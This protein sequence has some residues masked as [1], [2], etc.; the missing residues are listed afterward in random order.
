LLKD[1]GTR[2]VSF[3]VQSFNDEILRLNGRANKS[4]IFFEK[5]EVARKLGFDIVSVDLMSGLYGET[6]DNWNST[7][8]RLLELHPDNIA[9]Y[10]LE[11]YY[12]T[13]LFKMVRQESEKL[14]PLMTNDQEIALI[15]TAFDRL[16][17]EGKYMPANCFTLMSSPAKEH[18]HRKGIWQ[19]E[20][21]LGLGLS[22]H[23]YFNNH[24]YQNTP[25]MDDYCRVL[26][27]GNLPIHRAYR[28]TVEDEISMVMI[29]GIKNLRIDRDIFKRKFGVDIT[30]IYGD[31]IEEMLKR[32]YM[33]LD[34]KALSVNREYYIFADDIAREFFLPRYR[35][36]MLAH[37]LR[38]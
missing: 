8:N 3:G 26:G 38:N 37:H 18:V 14:P 15:Q 27:T 35:N 21:M 30:D 4:A 31:K 5:Y 2:R 11:V 17:D 1:L 29:Y 19:G 7:I 20:E 10:K 24:F 12:N 34:D 25:S 23:S 36:L 22:A 16:Q 28:C 32:G 6:P 13:G 9:F 33:S